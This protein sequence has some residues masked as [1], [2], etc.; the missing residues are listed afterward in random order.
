MRLLAAPAVALMEAI[1]P[2]PRYFL[3]ALFLNAPLVGA[4]VALKDSPDALL[5]PGFLLL[6]LC[7]LVSDYLVFANHLS[8]KSG[9][10]RFMEGMARFSSGDLEQRSTTANRGELG[11][12][13]ARLQALGADLVPVLEQIRDGAETVDRS[14]REVAAGHLNLSQRTEEQTATLEETASGMEELAATV[15]QNAASCERADALAKRASEAA[16]NGAQTVYRAVER[17]QLIDQSAR[18]IVDIIGVIQGIAFQ[19]NILALN[20][21]VEAARAGEQGRGFAVV[22]SEVRSLAQRSAQAASEIKVL[23]DESVAH[24]GEGGKLV[25][26]AGQAM[27]GVVVG[28]QQVT[29]L[30]GEIA[31][32]SKQQS[33][34]VDQIATAISQ[35]E[36]VTQQNAALVEEA[37]AAALAFQQ[38][39]QRVAEAVSKFKFASGTRPAAPQAAPRRQPEL[40]LLSPSA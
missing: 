34:G 33:A 2:G 40:A 28:V 29:E 23:I 11:V 39:A 38:E 8:A 9:L 6:A 14:A 25:G 1:R 12:T 15:K 3:L 17:M 7:Y 22:A 16:E 19:T 21:A 37:T 31:V 5:S 13:L 18:S 35:M 10:A 26:E 4:L 20:A 27:N 24:M 30:I 32:A 36:G